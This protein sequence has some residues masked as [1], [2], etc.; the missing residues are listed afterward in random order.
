M[1]AAGVCVNLRRLRVTAATL[2]A[3]RPAR[4]ALLQALEFSVEE[5]GVTTV[6]IAGEPF[7]IFSTLEAALAALSLGAEDLGENPAT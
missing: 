6:T 3:Q 2:D 7:M 4:R 1:T 5:Q